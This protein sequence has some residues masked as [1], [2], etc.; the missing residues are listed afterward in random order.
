MCIDHS[1][2]VKTGDPNRENINPN[3]LGT[4][5][6]TGADEADNH[7]LFDF[8]A[9]YVRKVH[10]DDFIHKTLKLGK[11]TSFIDVIGPNNIA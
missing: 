1:F 7:G 4:L 11:G 9:R 8:F 10:S 5:D 6:I 2:I 3:K